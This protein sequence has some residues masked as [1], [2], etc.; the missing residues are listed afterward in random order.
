[1]QTLMCL[2]W[3]L[4]ICCSCGVEAYGPEIGRARYSATA[5]PKVERVDSPLSNE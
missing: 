1:M 3:S 2:V 5:L 4:N